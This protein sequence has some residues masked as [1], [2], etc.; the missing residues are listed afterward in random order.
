ME[1]IQTNSSNVF[2]TLDKNITPHSAILDN[3]ASN[4]IIS[5][6][7]ITHV[8]DIADCDPDSSLYSIAGITSYN[9]KGKVDV[10]IPT[11]NS[12]H[13]ELTLDVLIISEKT[14]LFIIS[15]NQIVRQYSA[16]VILQPNS[17][18]LKVAGKEI[19]IITRNNVSYIDYEFTSMTT[20]NNIYTT[21]EML[22]KR[23]GHINNDYIKKG[24]NHLRDT[25]RLLSAPSN[26]SCE[27]CVIS[28]QS[29]NTYN[30]STQEVKMLDT[31]SADLFGRISTKSIH[32]ERYILVIQEHYTKY[33]FIKFLKDKDSNTIT[34]TILQVI[35]TIERQQSP[36]RLKQFRCDQGTEFHEVCK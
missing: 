6:K 15:L 22:H 34:R 9:K 11:T 23:L 32:G 3:A 25:Q 17:N 18:L 20:R 29:R 35:H 36:T 12:N 33:T 30:S 10:R 1:D 27:D 4:S 14:D 8:Y 24:M 2:T 19:E 13:V 16:V 7:Y 26:N 28:K 21:I 5:E 31:V